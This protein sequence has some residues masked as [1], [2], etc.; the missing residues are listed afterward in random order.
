[1]ALT[2]EQRE[3]LV[4]TLSADEVWVLDLLILV[5]LRPGAFEDDRIDSLTHVFRELFESFLTERRRYSQAC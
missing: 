5:A 3:H 1:M 4:G 2:A